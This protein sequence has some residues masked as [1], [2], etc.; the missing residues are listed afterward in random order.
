LHLDSELPEHLLQR[1]SGQWTWLVVIDGL[2]E[3]TDPGQRAA[4]IRQLAARTRDDDADLRLLITTR[5]LQD[6]ELEPFRGSTVGQYQLEPFSRER[7]HDFA[8]RWFGEGE[9]EAR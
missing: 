9:H 6:A 1:S 2:D 5:P 8:C 4:L 7:R 3:I